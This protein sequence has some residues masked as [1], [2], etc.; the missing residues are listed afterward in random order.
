MIEI[1]TCDTFGVFFSTC[2]SG[3]ANA[4]RILNNMT[5]KERNDFR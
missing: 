4:Y 2:I 1:E 5:Q 3:N